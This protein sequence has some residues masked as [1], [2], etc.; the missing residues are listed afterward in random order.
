MAGEKIK[1]TILKRIFKK[2]STKEIEHLNIRVS[3]LL[4][5]I[6]N[7]QN[8][9][10]EFKTFLSEKGIIKHLFRDDARLLKVVLGKIHQKYFSEN[11]DN[12]EYKKLIKTFLPFMKDALKNDEKLKGII[13]NN[14]LLNR[15]IF[16]DAGRSD[17]YEANYELFDSFKSEQQ[18]NKNNN[19]KVSLSGA[20]SLF[21]RT[22]IVLG[23]DNVTL[24]FIDKEKRERN[25]VTMLIDD[26]TYKMHIS[27]SPVQLSLTWL[28]KYL[29]KCQNNN[30][31]SL[32]QQE[33]SHL[34]KIH[35]A[36]K[37]CEENINRVRCEQAF[38]HR[39]QNN[40]L[41]Y[42]TSG[43]PGHAV[44]IA[45]Y[46]DY[47]VYCN[48]GHGA[49]EDNH[50]TKIYKL[51]NGKDSITADFLLRLDEMI[52]KPEGTIK[53]LH[54][55]LEEVVDLHNP[56]VS[57]PSK[58][59]EHGNCGFANPK[60][61]IEAMLV[62]V[63]NDGNDEEHLKR[64]VKS[65]DRSN[66][67]PYK[68][69]TEFM[70]DQAVDELIIA[71]RNT[72]TPQAQQVCQSLVKEFIFRCNGTRAR[73]S[74]KAK[75]DADRTV[76]VWESIPDKMR[77]NLKNDPDMKA[78]MTSTGIQFA[79]RTNQ[80]DINN[81]IDFM[82]QDELNDVFKFAIASNRVDILEFLLS[83]QHKKV[84]EYK[85]GF[86]IENYIA[87]ILICDNKFIE[88]F[89]NRFPMGSMASLL[90]IARQVMHVKHD[91]IADGVEKLISL[92]QARDLGN[93][94]EAKEALAELSEALERKKQVKL[95]EASTE[96][97]PIKAQ[98]SAL[99][100]REMYNKARNP[101]LTKKGGSLTFFAVS[102]VK[103][104]A[105]LKENTTR[106]LQIDVLQ[107]LVDKVNNAPKEKKGQYNLELYC[108]LHHMINIIQDEKNKLPSALEKVCNELISKMEANENLNQQIVEAYCLKHNPSSK[109]GI[110][111]TRIKS[112]AANDI[113]EEVLKSAMSNKNKEDQ[114]KHKN[115]TR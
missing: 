41:V 44:G 18:P 28:N 14:V 31:A 76:K 89:V 47:L 27:G 68:K 95:T 106:T 39:Y 59:Q 36:M 58:D 98:G 101:P 102:A 40:E 94:E 24:R 104:I 91:K 55:A 99:V 103:N 30:P 11:G 69:I 54:Q 6:E 88:D 52:Y 84:E 3:Q 46:G 90:T 13:K 87:A 25:K 5:L 93:F 15:W 19:V 63:E 53:D 80:L 83:S 74:A 111:I 4:S 61:T 75:N 114:R 85:R 77:E 60:A 79:I 22:A 21:N 49:L 78:F 57:L 26:N 9:N 66:K 2:E 72:E 65:R 10:E 62:L 81:Q 7:N 97:A 43:C 82:S 108:A 20:I 38:L 100:I 113:G 107:E 96:E 17:I 23:F 51:K 115:T 73:T 48:R 32:S 86:N 64:I 42:I 71:C 110:D 92:V 109:N 70:R 45:L 34:K 35:D 50:G 56:I 8:I 12:V 1:R 33:M 105:S 16:V 29:E 67:N 112:N 37:F